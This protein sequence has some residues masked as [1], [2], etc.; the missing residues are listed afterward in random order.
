MRFRVTGYRNFE[1]KCNLALRGVAQPTQPNIGLDKLFKPNA[2]LFPD[3]RS[4]VN[5][6]LSLLSGLR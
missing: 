5:S 3:C 4:A 1:E 2:C 6:R